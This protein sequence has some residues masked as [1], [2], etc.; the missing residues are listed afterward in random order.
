M[1]ATFGSSII[2]GGGASRNGAMSTVFEYLDLHP[3]FAVGALVF[4]SA[5][6][7]GVLLLPI[8]AR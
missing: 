5:L 8:L 7:L 2:P 4:H 3:V 6:L 1:Y